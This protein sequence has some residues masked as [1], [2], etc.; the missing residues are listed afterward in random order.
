MNVLLSG[1]G[2][3]IG[4]ALAER[5]SA[6][7]HRVARLVRPG[8]E[9]RGD[10][11]TWDPSAGHIDTAALPACDAVVHLAGESIAGRWGRKKKARIRESRIR[12][13]RLLCEALAGLATRPKVLAS[14]SAVGFYGSRGEKIVTE[15]DPPGEGFLASVCSE[16]EAATAAACEAGIRV[17]HLRTAMVLA[18]AGGALKKML[19]PFRL[20]LGGR[21]GSG[22][23]YWSWISLDDT[24]A[25]ILHVL[26]D[27][28]LCGPVNL[29]SPH[30]VTNRRFTR[31]LGRVLGRPT[32]FPMPSFAARL[33]FG[34]MAEEV[35][36]SST[37]VEPRRL[38]QSGFE[39]RHP[40]LEPALRE[41]LHQP[42]V[43]PPAD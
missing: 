40:E 5:L 41:L 43:R 15:D 16:W 2:G 36:L 23:Q 9:P 3:L 1:S 26:R 38:L 12:G 19:T 27:E 6:D 35:L 22:R 42:P 30:A 11:V 20:G 7:G 29:A 17:V 33:A 10:D 13:T 39:F 31:A 14:A 32:L 25:A 4:S 37:R 18:A 24:V 28:S 8:R 34:E 21:L